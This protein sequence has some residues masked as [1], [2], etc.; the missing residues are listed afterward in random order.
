MLGIPG[1]RPAAEG[2]AKLDVG[3]VGRWQGFTAPIPI[4]SAQ[5]RS[6]HAKLRWINAPLE[7]ASATASIEAD[8][9]T[10]ERIVA[11]IG[12]THWT[13]RVRAPRHCTPGTDGKGLKARP[14]EIETA[15]CQ[16][17]FDLSADSLSKADLTE[18]FSEH[19]TK[20]PWYRVLDTNSENASNAPAGAPQF[21]SMR[22]QGTLRVGRFS[23][24]G[25][26]ATR[27]SSILEFERGK[28]SLTGLSGELLQGTHHG[29]W[30]VDFTPPVATS[31]P[32]FR[33][34]GTVSNISL[35]QVSAAMNDSWISGV[36]DATYVVSGADLRDLLHNAEAKVKFVMLNGSLPHID[37]ADAAQPLRVDRFSGDLLLNAGEW[38]LPDAILKSQG[39]RYKVSG[40]ATSTKNLDFV[41]NNDDDRSWS[42]TGSLAEPH[43][44]R[45]GISTPEVKRTEAD[46]K[47]PAAQVQ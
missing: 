32:K 3:I 1:T 4:G 43:I 40:T 31:G 25:I 17:Q 34:T 11:R 19:S 37:L 27:V 22:A 28:L 14:S 15:K 2:L 7:I 9:L 29:N 44:A 8:S 41:L 36:A 12:T 10:L 18:W 33:G 46:V 16:F 39:D 6:V 23:V 24:D 38:R 20:R 35:D 21:L 13:G 42:I 30:V 26:T 45:S 5:L 47:A